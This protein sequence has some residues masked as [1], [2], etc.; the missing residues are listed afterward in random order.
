MEKKEIGRIGEDIACRF[1][2]KR[3]YQVIERNYLKK[4]G[5][6][7]VVARK[8]RVVHFVEVKTVS[9]EN[10]N[11]KSHLDKYRPEDNLHF[12]KLSRLKKVI[13]IYLVQRRVSLDW[14]FDVITVLYY[15]LNQEARVEFLENLIL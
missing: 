5:E 1:L 10:P 9:C 11:A 12:Y 8:D 15:S 6:I 7:D 13:Q 3:G 14:Q 2:M 4:C